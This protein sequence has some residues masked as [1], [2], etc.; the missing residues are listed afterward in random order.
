[1]HGELA[2][3]PDVPIIASSED[4][5]LVVLS[6]DYRNSPLMAGLGSGFLHLSVSGKHGHQTDRLAWRQLIAP[7]RT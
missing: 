1:M 3:T 7:V 4:S 5:L 2:W 6:E